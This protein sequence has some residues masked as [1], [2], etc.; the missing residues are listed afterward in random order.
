MRQSRGVP[1]RGRE[2]GG[3]GGGWGERR[4]EGG[5]GEKE[6][7]REKRGKTYGLLEGTYKK[8]P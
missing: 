5:G 3:D 6:R 2:L 1:E 7:D 8:V 4:S